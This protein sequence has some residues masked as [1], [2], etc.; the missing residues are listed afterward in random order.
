VGE[1]T[2]GG[3]GVTIGKRKKGAAF[4]KKAKETGGVGLKPKTEKFLGKKG[5][6]IE[7]SGLW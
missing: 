4:V 1:R 7:K 3:L 5:R 2:S 6:G